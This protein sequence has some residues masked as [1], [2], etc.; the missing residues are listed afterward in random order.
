MSV[1]RIYVEKRPGFFDTPAQKLCA[2]L[3]NMF[4]VPDL[5]AVRIFRRY[6]IEGMT[7]EEFAKARN[8][9]FAEPP[10]DIIYDENLPNI[11]AT[12][13]FAVEFLPGQ[14]DQTA[15]SAAQC[16]QLIT[17]KERPLVRT[18]KIIALVGNIDDKSFSKIK[19]YCINE[20]ECREAS[21]EKP[22]TLSMQTQEPD[23]VQ[24]ID[25]FI[26]MTDN[27]INT[28][29][30]ELGL[31]MSYEDFLFCREYFSKQEHRD[32]TI[33]EIRVI[34]TYWSDH[35][36]HTTFTTAIDS[37]SIDDNEYTQDIKNTY[38]L[39]L[40]DRA[41][42]YTDGRPVT[43]MDLAVIGM[44]KLKK[45]GKLADLDAS[46]EINAC[47]IVVPAIVNGKKENWLVM[48]KN[49]THN[50][51][52]EIEPFGGAAT[53]LGGAIRDP[54][55]GRSYV[56]QAMR[57]TGAA[58]PRRSLDETIEG[59]L[60]QRK[61][62]RDAALGYSSYG[63]QI[64]LATGQVHEV[65]HD[66][67]LAKRLEI[68]AVV[69]AVPQENVVRQRP[70][71]GDLIILVGGRTGRDG[72]GGATGSSKEHTVESLESCGAEVQKGNPPTERKLQRLFRKKEVSHII[73]RCNDFGAGGVAVAIGEL[74]DGLHIEL[75]KIKKK[76][77]GLDGTELA[78]SESQ[79]RMAVVVDKNDAQK[80][81]EHAAEENLEATI[82][83]AVTDDNRLC[84]I[85][86]GKNIVSI[87]RAFLQTNGVQQHVSAK[88][89]APSKCDAYFS[90]Q[91]IIDKA[92]NDL[93]KAWL[94]NLQD[95]NVCNQKGLVEQF[96]STIGAGTLLMPYGGYTQRTPAEGM[97]AKLPIIGGNTDTGTLM[98]FGFDPYLMDW[99]PYHG[100]VYSIVTAL[101]KITAMG[102][103]YTHARLTFQEYFES[104]GDDAAKWGSPFAALLGT[105]RAQ[106][107][108]G[109][110]AIGGKDSMSGTFMDMHVPP[111]LI[112]FALC[113]VLVNKIVSS[114]FKTAGNKVYIVSAARDKNDLPLF[115]KLKENFAA[116]HKLT[117]A[118]KVFSAMSVG[119]GGVAAA[120]SKMCLGEN[121]GF[122]FDENTCSIPQIFD[123][124]YGSIIIETAGDADLSELSNVDFHLL[125]QITDTADI[126][127][128][129]I[130][131]SVDNIAKAFNS[132]LEG[133]FPTQVNTAASKGTDQAS[134]ALYNAGHIIKRNIPIAKPKVFIPVFP[135]TNC[136]Y[137]TEAA[138]R[139]AGAD[140]QTLI[141][142]NLTP[143]TVEESV[144]AIEKAI[145]ASQIV[146]LPGGFSGGDEPDGSGKFIAAT[147][148][149]PRIAE[150]I[151]K[152]LYQ[153]D[154]LMLGICNGFQAL[155]K[156]GL[157][158]YGKI[159]DLHSD[160]PTLTYNQIG[161]HISRMVQ[162]KVVSNLSPWLAKA[163][164][165]AIH[166]MAV[167]HGEGRFYA[168]SEAINTLRK[169]G[170]IATQYVDHNGNV[171]MD[172]AYNPNGSIDA[173]E[174]ITSPD[175]RVFGKMGHS[176]RITNDLAIN[177][178]GEKNQLLFES[179]VEYYR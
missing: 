46:E 155:I 153:R 79:E 113:P 19:K 14:F 126:V 131:L 50:H 101:A 111:S 149:N 3:K 59:K 89:A 61:I 80:F 83:A 163:S 12:S 166:T 39:Y 58:D 156:L 136:E 74:S 173:I 92:E 165:D 94:E 67:F 116:I 95:L 51:P 71:T 88:I 179:G 144:M 158:P 78:I 45:L 117:D 52:T 57:V 48:F 17:Q 4:N 135:G 124:S 75:D 76:Y 60:P 160:S 7:A 38:N 104:L 103:D 8:V 1:R 98:S 62:T 129:N 146:M 85:W 159:C 10:V 82:V 127:Y 99:S 119:K 175:G 134:S 87:S 140:V 84:M 49:E 33:T 63:N 143:K 157:L 130:S 171:S 133:I 142:K 162:T 172:I 154:G 151:E 81:I 24:I 6:D 138:F 18:A 11:N 5:R 152:L 56:Y 55:S 42:I 123:T 25:G 176:E 102:G 150:A 36:R 70:V 73:K 30:D 164:L 169:N 114:E 40:K 65:Y 47:S 23:D 147:F 16:V 72:I 90:H 43:L 31:A 27:E 32:P 21:M 86:R 178:P 118:K 106:H 9:V 121:L 168:S 145:N 96:D 93:E 41:D 68:G 29:H 53:C 110:A 100:A 105:L 77:E 109:T 141:I 97:A 125:G 28:L 44:K 108:F 107:E 91:S 177:I 139:R 170:Q 115:D 13:I 2:D 161:R 37:V 34:D 132:P 112:A 137:D 167:S 120:I 69:G 174:G 122:K 148:R 66:G 54:L 22:Q 15:D 64:G 26:S 20:V 128:G 35:C